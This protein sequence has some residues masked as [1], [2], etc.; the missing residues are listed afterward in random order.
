M[1]LVSDINIWT[2]PIEWPRWM[3]NRL[4]QATSSFPHATIVAGGPEV[5]GNV[6]LSG[7]I[8]NDIEG[9]DRLYRAA[10]IIRTDGTVD[11]IENTTTTQIDSGTDWIIPNGD[12]S[13][14]YEVRYTN[15]TGDA[16]DGSTSL[17]ED[18]WGAISS[19]RY[20]EQRWSIGAGVG[21]KSSVFDLEIRFNGGSVLDSAQYQLNAERL[22]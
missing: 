2:P 18:T 10:V 16:L 3:L 1:I 9:G 13:S 17:A 19:D 15:R 8:I 6:T 4:M 20:F 12:A 14:S 5:A 7:E 22:F 21:G 11:K